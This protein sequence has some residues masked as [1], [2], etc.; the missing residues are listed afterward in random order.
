MGERGP[1]HERLPHFRLEFTPSAGAE[2]QTEYL[3]PRQ[4][5]LAALRAV[6]EL[7]DRIAPLLLVTE[8]RSIAADDLWLSPFYQQPCL[9][10]HFT[11]QPAWPSVR[12]LLPEIEERL[13]PFRRA[14]ALGQA[15]HRRARAGA[16]ALPAPARLPAAGGALRPAGKFRNEFV[17]A[18]PLLSTPPPP[19]P[20]PLPGEAR[21]CS[22]GAA[23]LPPHQHYNFS[24][25]SPNGRGGRG[26][27]M[28]EAHARQCSKD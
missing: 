9:G 23:A 24:T 13:A 2:L 8:L 14:P 7:R 26:E 21:S 12:A 11:W 28:I 20:L 22:A 18:D 3:V 6:G 25:P 5:A 15:V 1:W 27:G 17:E 10:M 19:L 16:R 4:H